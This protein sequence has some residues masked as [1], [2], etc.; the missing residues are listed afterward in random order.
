MSLD[1]LYHLVETLRSRSQKYGH[2]LSKNEAMT[3]Y[4]LIDP[5]LRSLGWDTENPDVVRA[6]F[7]PGQ[8]SADYALLDNDRPLIFVEAKPLGQLLDHGVI[9]SI[10]YCIQSGTPYFVI[11]DG[12]KWEIYKTHAPVPLP[13]KRIAAFDLF[14]GNIKDAV[15]HLLSLWQPGTFVSPLAVQDRQDLAQIMLTSLSP[16]S[17]ATIQAGGKVSQEKQAG[18]RSTLDTFVVKPGDKAP[19][20]V[21]DPG[22]ISHQVR[23]WKDILSA[24]ADWLSNQGLLTTAD[25]PVSL[26]GGSRHLVG[27]VPKHPS[28][29]DFFQ[30]VKVGAMWLETHASATQIIHESRYLVHRF[31]KMANFKIVM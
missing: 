18:G 20:A 5:V 2:L 27:V 30:P 23:A 9:Q 10:N 16:T 11:T 6:E 29:R 31:G 24:V 17:S 3:R 7:S 8:G 26:P 15:L 4:V 28:G 22:G 14:Q 1:D 25:C 19:T 21:V 12:L 13:E